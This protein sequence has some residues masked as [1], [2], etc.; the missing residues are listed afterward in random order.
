MKRLVV[1][2]VVL[3]AFTLVGCAGTPEP[4]V[5]VNVTNTVTATVTV[6]PKPV[7]SAAP[8]S[9]ALVTQIKQDYPG[10]PLIVS[11]GS[12][13]SRVASAYKDR[14]SNDRVVALAP[15]VYTP[16][17]PIETDLDVYIDSAP[18]DGD[19]VAAHKLF[20]DRSGACWDGVQAGGGEPSQ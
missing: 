11:V 10:Y 5:T 6:T 19:C 15:G 2:V 18:V 12:I 3:F 7:A 14:L 9:S 20:S 17:N 16:Y 13:D 4:A 8:R 1:P